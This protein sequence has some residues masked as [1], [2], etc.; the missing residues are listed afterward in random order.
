MAYTDL[1]NLKLCSVGYAEQTD[2]ATPAGGSYTYVP[3]FD[4]SI[5]PEAPSA[6]PSN[7]VGTRGS[8]P[9]NTSGKVWYRLSFKTYAHGQPSD[10]DFTSDTA[11]LVGIWGLL[12]GPF[13]AALGAYHAT[14]VNASDGNTVTLTNNPTIGSL[15]AFA[16]SSN[17]VGGMGFVKSK[18]GGGPYTTNLFED[19]PAQPGSNNKQVPTRALYPTVGKK[20]FSFKILG[21]PAAQDIRLYGGILMKRTGRLDEADC[22]LFEWEFMVY[23]SMNPRGGSGGLQA[24][25]DFLTLDPF[26]GAGTGRVVLGS[27]VFTDFNDGTADGEGHCDVRDIVFTDEWV[28]RPVTLASLT[29][30][31][32]KDVSV[33]AHTCR[34]SFTVPSVTNYDSSSVNAF[35]R[36]FLEKTQVSFSLYMGDT[37]GRLYAYQMKRGQVSAFPG[38]PDVDGVVGRGVELVA[39]DY[40]GDGASTD[41]GNKPK[42]EAIG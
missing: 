34:V 18:S 2:V 33:Q 31:G 39:T 10:Y 30:G 24:L 17:V 23:G 4:L 36:A 11:D 19:L 13:T 20:I 26:V 22:L 5:T 16:N 1:L 9:R 35:E 21:E 7:G 32:V 12:D 27:N 25:G 41:A 6:Q 14:G 29:G 15:I 28:H 8:V 40:S 42:V 3:A 38:Y 37:P